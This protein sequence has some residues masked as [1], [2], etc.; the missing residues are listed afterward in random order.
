MLTSKMK[1]KSSNKILTIGWDHKLIQ[2]IF[3]KV[4][5]NAD[6]N[7]A[8]FLFPKDYYFL[9]NHKIN[10]FEL[11]KVDI[12]KNLKYKIN[13][14]FLKELEEGS[15]ITF[16]NI[17]LSDRVLREKK[18]DEAYW[19]ISNLAEQMH[20]YVS[21]L[22]PLYLIGSWD[23]VIQGVGML[24]A[25][26]LDIPFV[27]LKY[28]VI[29]RNHLSICTYP[30]NYDEI[31]FTSNTYDNT[32]LKAK[33][34]RD[35][36]INGFEKVPAYES[37]KS[38]FDVIR[39]L[40]THINEIINRF[41][42][43]L[44]FGRNSF[45]NFSFLFLFRQF[46]R[47]K[48]NI[49]FMRKSIVITE[50]PNEKFIFYGLHMQPESSIDVMAPFHSN[51]LEIV[52]SISRA[53]PINYKVLV[54]I[55]ISDADNY[56]SKQL[57]EFL[58]IPNVILVS[59]F[60]GSKEFILSSDLLISIQGTIALEGALLGKPVIVFGNSAYLKFSTVKKVN[61]I[62]DLPMLVEKQLGMIKVKDEQIL[63]DYTSLMLNYLPSS[64]DDWPTTL[65]NKLSSIEV[66]NYAAIFDQLSK[67]IKEGKFKYIN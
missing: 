39:I 49:L 35:N 1:E 9:K 67:Y 5:K 10:D 37:S 11:C 7:F 19:Y 12:N 64:S 18:T 54:K 48:A 8:H 62:E 4:Q 38:I 41:N 58:N 43:D 28:S 13:F 55:H 59:P 20:D 65:K 46:L 23:A 16:N 21:R 30:N 27:V 50:V 52:K 14:K 2:E 57:K 44:K 29:P 47:K 61:I 17:I 33:K 22:S 42:S 56:S 36:W 31:P 3:P 45:L 24:V 51:Q 66:S 53:A 25:K 15:N 63:A 60:V 34:A 6:L 40:P 32:Y 26:K